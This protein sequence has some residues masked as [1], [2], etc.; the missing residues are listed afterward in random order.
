MLVQVLDAK[1]S[2]Y[3]HKEKLR[4][5]GFRY[6]RDP[7]SDGKWQKDCSTVEL[8]SVRKFCRRNGLEYAVYEAG[9]TRSTNYRNKYFQVHKGFLGKYYQ[10]AYC[11]KIK[12]KKGITVDHLIPVDKV[13]KGKRRDKYIRKLKK[14]GITDVNDVR[15]LVPACMKCNQK[16]SAQTGIWVLRGTLGKHPIYWLTVWFFSL[17]LIVFFIANWQAILSGLSQIF[18]DWLL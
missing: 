17:L 15:N 18:I 11:G 13:I 16:K 9:Y 12:T 5:M 1:E 8:K 6:I 2:V 10:C 14:K 4:R 3:N 7:A